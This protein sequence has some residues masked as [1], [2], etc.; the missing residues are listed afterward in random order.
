MKCFKISP[1]DF[2]Q[3]LKQPEVIKFKLQATKHIYIYIDKPIIQTKITAINTS[4]K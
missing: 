3:A 4:H 1:S 2:F